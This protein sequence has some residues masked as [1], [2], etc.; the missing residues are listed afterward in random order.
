METAF[1]TGGSGYVGR[2]L[3]KAL[4]AKGWRVRSL[5]RSAK[6]AKVVEACGAEAVDGDLETLDAMR[7]G[8]EGCKV[9]FHSAA[10]LGDWG[11]YEDFY[12]GNV[13][14]TENVLRMARDSNVSRFIHVGTEAALVGGRAIISATEDWPLPEKPMGFYPITKGLAEKRVLS[15]NAPDFSTIVM[16]P[17]FIWGKD[18]TTLLPRFVESVQQ[19]KFMWINGGHYLTSTCHVDNVCEGLILAAERGRGGECYFLTDG[20]PVEVREFF[21]ALIRSQGLEPG[22]KSIPRWVATLFA[23][24]IETVWKIFKLSGNPPITRTA[25]KLIGEEVTVVDTKAR[26]ELGYQALVSREAGLAE[27]TKLSKKK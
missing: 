8:M 16:R 25:V 18:D 13:V 2:N 10:Y 14:G 9:V 15:V 7:K 3:I 21:T 19:G 20:P 22:N 27:L 26:K 24:L 1:V 11:R 17:R 12:R 5:V 6:A 23:S 4:I